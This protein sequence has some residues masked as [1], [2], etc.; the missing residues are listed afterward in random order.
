MRAETLADGSA[1]NDSLA[2][3][4]RGV[5]RTTVTPACQSR[6]APM[7]GC[8]CTALRAA[9]SRHD[10]KRRGTRISLTAVDARAY[11][12]LLNGEVSGRRRAPSREPSFVR[13]V[14]NSTA[15]HFN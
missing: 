3:G 4:W 15:R 10:E 1:G 11:M 14:H 9:T 6:K 8:C 12:I 7:A 2:D 13:V 5:Q